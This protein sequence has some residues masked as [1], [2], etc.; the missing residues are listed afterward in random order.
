MSRVRSALIAVVLS[1]GPAITIGCVRAASPAPPAPSSSQPL[2]RGQPVRVTASGW[3]MI[4][5]I[6]NVTALSADSITVTQGGRRATLPLLG[7]QS[8]EVSRGR[9]SRWLSSVGIG[10]GV[11]A[12]VGLV[13]L[14]SCSTV[15]CGVAPVVDPV[16][17]AMIGG[18]VG[19]LPGP[20]QW[21]PVPLD[22]LRGLRIGM[23]IQPARRVALGASLAF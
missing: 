4:K 5:D 12:A 19:A 8:L 10:A 20:E 23:V 3:G 7:L 1:L 14:A 22:A 21:E 6:V 15:A 13:Y 17:G 2:E 16:L 11:G 9:H 18:I